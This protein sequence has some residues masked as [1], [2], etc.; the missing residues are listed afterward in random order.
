MNVK[1]KI[2]ISS[3]LS[4]F[5]FVAISLSTVSCNTN[6]NSKTEEDNAANKEAKINK[7]QKEA[8][9]L[10]LASKNYINLINYSNYIKSKTTITKKTKS[11]LESFE[12]NLNE[13][14]NHLKELSKHELVLLPN[15]TKTSFLDKKK[16]TEEVEINQNVYL[17][18]L[19]T[20]INDQIDLMNKLSEESNKISISIFASEA[21][22][23]LKENKR[24]IENIIDKS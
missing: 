2:L 24:N 6:H 15:T 22:D 3:L 8:K 4:I 11:F 21:E 7:S 16:T 5:M 17:T 20:K 19:N 12:A 13:R 14:F 9:L 23:F 1:K 18:E 10:V